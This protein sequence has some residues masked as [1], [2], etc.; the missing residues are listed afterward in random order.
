MN[1]SL[2][3]PH[4]HQV[5][6]EGIASFACRQCGR[7]YHIV[8]GVVRILDKTDDFYEG[9]YENQT[10]FLPRS[11]KPWYVWPL[12]LINSGYVWMVRKNV[13]VGAT[14][15]E[16]GCASGVR[17]FG[18]RYRMIGC[19]LSFSSLKK[20]D[21][22]ERRIQAD[23]ALCIALP[24]GSV[25]AVVSSYF[26]EHIPPNVKPNI[27]RECQRILKPSGKLV[28]L[29]D[30][31]TENPLIQKF[32]K[33]DLQRY[34]QLFIDGDGHVGYQTIDENLELFEQA[35][36]HVLEHQGL[37]KTCVQSPSTYDKLSRFGTS[38]QRPLAWASGFGRH[39]FFYPYT[40]FMRLVDTWICPLLPDRWARIA[41]TIC[42]K[43][44]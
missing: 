35:G 2:I 20:L 7:E 44:T 34:R 30:V 23:A 38:A 18:Q 13:P 32:I 17:Y 26:W 37:E 16:L 42:Q 11:E 6:M 25:D 12:W 40:A 8:E 21:F 31:E 24:D 19:D 10:H 39:P 29:F 33:R 36:F 22:Y 9:S 14:V 4:D 27:L 41:M 3:C 28:F 15:V 5:L 43:Q 1:I